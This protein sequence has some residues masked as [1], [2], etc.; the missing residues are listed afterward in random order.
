MNKQD[1]I[2]VY[3]CQGLWPL[4]VDLSLVPDCK[5]VTLIQIPAV[6][7]TPLPAQNNCWKDHPAPTSHRSSS[8][9]TWLLCDKPAQNTLLPVPGLL[10]YCN[11]L[12]GNDT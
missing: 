1:L 4:T 12:R 6:A 3:S 11:S 8:Q 10:F 7:G 9:P 5:T 2:Q